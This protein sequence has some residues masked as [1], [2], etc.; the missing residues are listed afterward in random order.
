MCPCD[1]MEDHASIVEGLIVRRKL[2][3]MVCKLSSKLCSSQA[4]K[5]TA[6]TLL[7]CIQEDTC[8]QPSSADVC[9][10][11]EVPEATRRMM[12]S[13]PDGLQGVHHNRAK[14][15]S[16]CDPLLKTGRLC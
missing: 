7:R 9:L 4:V 14:R 1:V 15:N 13:G 16:C 8:G 11:P 3:P 6:V 5:L 2:K 12:H 10:S